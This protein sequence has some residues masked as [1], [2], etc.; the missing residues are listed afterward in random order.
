MKLFL[1]LPNDRAVVAPAFKNAKDN[2]KNVRELII[3]EQKFNDFT[4]PFDGS[5]E[6]LSRLFSDL[7][8]R[9]LSHM[10]IWNSK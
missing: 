9:G 2:L 5:I 6:E 7:R 8:L 4:L 10:R 3:F 1:Y